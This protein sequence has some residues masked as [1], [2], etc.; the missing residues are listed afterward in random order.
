MTSASKP[1]HHAWYK[2]ARWERRRQALFAEQPLCVMCLSREEVTIA[3]TADHVVPHRGDPV[4]FWHGELQP[5]CTACHS[6]DKQ[7]EE[8]GSHELGVDASGWPVWRNG[9]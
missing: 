7:R 9:D 4:L 2:L 6:R 5:L 3:D 1:A 8:I